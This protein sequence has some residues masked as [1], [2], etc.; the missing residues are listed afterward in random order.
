MYYLFNNDV[1]QAQRFMIEICRF[2]ADNQRNNSIAAI[3]NYC[4][5]PSIITYGVRV[6]ALRIGHRDCIPWLHMQK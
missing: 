1:E 2:T 6:C 3:D 5:L 4:E